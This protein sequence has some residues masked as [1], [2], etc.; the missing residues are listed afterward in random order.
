[1]KCTALGASRA[2]QELKGRK[3][4]ASLAWTSPEGVTLKP[5]YTSEDLEVRGACGRRAALAG[6]QA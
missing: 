2:S 3:D 4:P 6:W 1:M 5:I